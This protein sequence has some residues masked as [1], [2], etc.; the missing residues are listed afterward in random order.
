MVS[1]KIFI[2]P[3]NIRLFKILYAPLYMLYKGTIKYYLFIFQ[4]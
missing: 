1:G 4:S 2:P 3:G